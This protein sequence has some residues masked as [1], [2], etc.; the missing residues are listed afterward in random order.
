[1]VKTTIEVDNE[2]WKR[3][4]LLVLYERGSRKKNEVIVELLKNYVSQRDFEKD[5]IQLEYIMR[6][7]E[8]RE[9]FQK[10]KKKLL[11]DPRYRGKYIAVYQGKIVGIGEE[12][13][14]LARKVYKKY[15][16][17]PIYIGKISREKIHMEVPSPE[18]NTYEV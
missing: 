16:Y 17:V 12:K 10:L 7:E 4:S 6:I 13:G 1:M 2:L 14:E 15:G 18:L 11:R 9:A 5:S 3:F 8:E